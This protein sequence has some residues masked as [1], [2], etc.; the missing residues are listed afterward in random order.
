MTDKAHTRHWRSAC[1]EAGS[2]V[3]VC[4][5]GEDVLVRS[6]RDQAGPVLTFTTQEW[7]NFC[8]G[9]V[10]GQLLPE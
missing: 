1:G 8:A 9:I 3:E 4:Y 7:E 10:S 5:E 2:C 6:S